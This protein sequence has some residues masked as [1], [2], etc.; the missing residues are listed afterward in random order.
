[1]F[2]LIRWMFSLALFLM[3]LWFATSVQLGKRT[4]WGHL[5]AIFATQEAK[6]LAEGTREEAKKVAD[7][8]RDEL[9]R[10]GGSPDRRVAPPAPP[11]DPVGTKEQRS[12]DKLVREKTHSHK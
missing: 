9:G 6:D 3:L 10:D 7:R 11:L 2:T 4:L 12:L 8:V 5:Q 1:M